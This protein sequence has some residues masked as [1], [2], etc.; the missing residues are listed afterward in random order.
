M[1]WQEPKA[2]DTS[3]YYNA[4]DINRENGNVAFIRDFLSE[5]GYSI[6]LPYPV[7][8]TYSKTSFPTV[9]AVNAIRGNIAALRA[10]FYAPPGAP[11]VAVTP[12]RKQIFNYA[13]ANKLE[14]NL[15]LMYELMYKLV[16]SYRRCGTFYC[17]EEG[18][19]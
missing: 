8:V 14:L 2:F 15:K 13:D 18:L 10:G 3:S 11:E 6:S 5:Q 9:S 4:E 7:T 17:G 1:A 19:L 12:T 16:A